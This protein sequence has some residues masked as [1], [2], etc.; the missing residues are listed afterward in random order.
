MA[1]EINI[2]ETETAPDDRVS[3]AG[4]DAMTGSPRSGGIEHLDFISALVLMVL[5]VFSSVLAL[6]YYVK[7]KKE[8]Y[9]SPGFMPM[10]IG[11]ILFLLSLSLLVQ[12]LKGSSL[13]E[14]F[15]QAA[16]AFRRGTGS[17]RFFN[18]AAGLAIFGVYIY[19]LLRF[20]PFW[21]ASFIFLAAVFMYLRASGIVKCVII[22][23]LSIGGI[24]LLFQ[25]AFRVPM[26]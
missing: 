22:A 5:C 13:K 7:S 2:N 23:A 14:R 9:A 18:S 24:V 19:A 12:S 21:L 15:G 10:L 8:F 20:L 6:S 26:P 25:I 1:K 11:V 3:G 16:A 17:R 4:L